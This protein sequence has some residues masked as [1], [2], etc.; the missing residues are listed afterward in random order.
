MKLWKRCWISIKR[1][2][3]QTLVQFLIVFILGNFLCA[4][5]GVQQASVQIREKLVQ[6]MPA[7]VTMILE[8]KNMI[9]ILEEKPLQ[10]I[11]ELKQE[12]NVKNVYS[13]TTM[14]LPIY[15]N[16]YQFKTYLVAGVSEKQDSIFDYEF[17]EGR[18]LTQEEIQNN[19]AKIILHESIAKDQY[20][21]NETIS[22]P[23]YDYKLGGDYFSLV[24][25]SQKME[26]MDFEIVGIFSDFSLKQEYQSGG[27]LFEIPMMEIPQQKMFEMRAIQE[28]LFSNHEKNELKQAKERPTFQKIQLKPLVTYIRVDV[29]GMDQAEELVQ[30]IKKNPNY[31]GGYY[32]LKT[33]AEDYRYVQAP[34]ENLVQLS[35]IT[36]WVSSILVI[37]L[38]SIVSLL[39]LKGRTH[40]IGILMAMGERK[41]KIMTQFILEI[42]LV[43]LL[44][45]SFALV[46]GN[47]LGNNISKQFISIQVD[48]DVEEE[49]LYQNPNAVTQLDLIEE[50]E[51]GL[52]FQY[53]GVI[54]LSSSVLLILSSALPMVFILNLKPKKILM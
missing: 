34:L 44:A 53:V 6:K 16:D 50:Y 49:Y 25:N 30:S 18:G 47:F 40:E 35:N 45:T 52:D 51:I 24:P 27:D 48:E 15:V 26:M 37:A 33:S 11:L 2:P 21:V 22:L 41:G 10:L 46:S 20:H 31:L 29:N 36:L 28:Q 38:L 13:Q 4:A 5:I 9:R 8:N 1:H 43:G 14:E 19:E 32:T 17:V 42:L 7:D 23:I 12:E 39:F 3:F 54:L